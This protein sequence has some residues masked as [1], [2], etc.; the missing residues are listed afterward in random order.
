VTLLDITWGLLGLGLI[1]YA[2]T[3]GA[4]WGGG[5]WH[6]L[7]RKQDHRALIEHAIA[8][9]W[10]VN[11][12]W[13]IF[14]IVMIFTV[15]PHAFAALSIALHWPFVAALIGL[16]LRGSAF[17]F[18]AYGMHA[19][20]KRHPWGFVFGASSLITPI[21]L[22]I[23]LAALASG[24]IRVADGALRSSFLAGWTNVFAV[25]VGLFTTVTFA[26]LAA[27]YLCVEADKPVIREAFRV[28]ALTSQCVAAVLGMLVLVHA[29]AYAVR[30]YD[31]YLGHPVGWVVQAIAGIAAL[32][33]LSALYFR[34]YKLARLC[35]IGEVI[36]IVIGW[37][38]GMNRHL[39]LPDLTIDGPFTNRGILPILLPALG[40]G[41]AVLIPSLYYLFRVFKLSRV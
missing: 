23:A 11:H 35:M 16:V 19:P 17:V 40:L 2:L 21:F 31:N 3:G 36:A 7:T 22:G 8:P 6:L 29:H 28:R 20:D 30:W 15:F 12:I 27:V 18:N 33:N 14:L 10:E 1:A 26:A 4:D 41:M 5:I 34:R 25:E 13:L 37:G 24:Q 32:F 9:I 39:A 38:L